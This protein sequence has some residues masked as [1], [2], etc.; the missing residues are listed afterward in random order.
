[1]NKTKW[2]FIIDSLMF[3]CMTAIAG[4]GLLMK[5]ILIPGKERWEVYGRNVDLYW[6]GMDR[7]DW[8]M[9]HFIIALTL[10]TLLVLHIILHWKTILNIFCK[11][12]GNAGKRKIIAWIFIVLSAVFLIFPVLIDPEVTDSGKGRGKHGY[13]YQDK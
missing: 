4:I 9:I 12:I 7:H 8:G 1:M 13:H 5:Y 10:L 6:F 2:N 11:L 3:L